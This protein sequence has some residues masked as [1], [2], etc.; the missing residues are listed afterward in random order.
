[1]NDFLDLVAFL[2][3][4]H[5]IFA[6]DGLLELKGSL[7][8]GLGGD[9]NL[10]PLG[11]LHSRWLPRSNAQFRTTRT[12]PD[13]NLHTQRSGR[14]RCKRRRERGHNEED[15]QR[16]QPQS[17]AAAFPIVFGELPGLEQR[18]KAAPQPSV[19]VGGLVLDIVK[20]MA[21]F[22]VALVHAFFPAPRA[23]AAGE[24]RP[25]G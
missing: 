15:P 25:A 10:Y 23:I 1:M 3:Q 13:I 12:L 22:E 8:A 19:Q 6:R 20:L 18:A 16:T 5:R 14:I 2:I 11:R 9:T 17:P 4:Q 7:V 21:E 24:C